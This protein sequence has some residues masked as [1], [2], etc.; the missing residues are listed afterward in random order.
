MTVE[1]FLLE[2][3]G[4]VVPHVSVMERGEEGGHYHIARVKLP[5]EELRLRTF[6]DSER[7]VL[8]NVPSLSDES[9]PWPTHCDTCEHEFTDEANRSGGA[10][11]V[12]R[13]PGTGQEYDEPRTAGPGAMWDAWWMPDDWKGADGR[14][15]VVICPDG[16]EWTIDGTASNCTRPGD[17]DH[18]CW[19]RYGEPPNV[20]VDK[21]AGPTCSAGAGSILVPGYHGFLRGGRFT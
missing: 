17:H 16:T 11:R 13:N 8:A 12:Y 4:E 5:R 6:E 20:T 14:C 21:N 7:L 3:T 18:R 9:L 15:L 1:C 2:E 10:S 19:P